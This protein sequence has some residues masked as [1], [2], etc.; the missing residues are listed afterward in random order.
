MSDAGR[1]DTDLVE[2]PERGERQDEVDPRLLEPDAGIGGYLVGLSRRLRGGDIGSSPVLVGLVIIWAIFQTRNHRFLSPGNIENLLLQNVDVGVIA[3]GIVLVLLLGEIDLS[4]GAVSGVTAGLMGVLTTN[5]GV[6]PLVSILAALGLGLG[7]GLLHGV[8]FTKIGIPAFVV[9]L[10]GL[11]GWAGLQLHITGK[12]GSILLSPHTIITELQSTFL[13][14]TA[15]WILAVV[16]VVAYAAATISGIVRR[17]RAGL[18]PLS[19]VD[20]AIRVVV[21][22]IAVFVGVFEVNRDRGVPLSVLIFVAL[23]VAF[24]LMLR[25]TQFGRYIYAVGGNIEAARRAGIR[26]DRIRIAVMTL[27][28]IM[29]AVGGI[30]AASRLTSV[31]AATGGNDVLLNSIAAA[32][33]G[34]TS[35]TG[36]RGRAWSALLGILVIGS[37]TNGLDLLSIG[38]DVREMITGGVL[39]AA[40]AVD[41]LARRGRKA[42]G[43]A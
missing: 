39:L 7:I 43:R 10:A 25:R 34:G 9:T 15:G 11:L 2:R 29:A 35:L 27:A 4:V 37:I 30:L 1:S 8:V 13:S 36:G 20:L 28:S 17:R 14:D 32:V 23:V 12:S 21:V 3:L 24:D 40:T 5:H 41:A 26:V 19:R 6:S 22:A 33:I 18:R 31:S 38:S 16:I 42:S